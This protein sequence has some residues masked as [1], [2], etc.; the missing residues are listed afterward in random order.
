MLPLALLRLPASLPAYSKLF[1]FGCGTCIGV[2]LVHASVIVQHG[3][4]VEAEESVETRVPTLEKD[5]LALPRLV[6]G[7]VH[8]HRNDTVQLVDLRFVQIVLGD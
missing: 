4:F 8:P 5:L 1:V 6:L 7:G 3:A 2:G